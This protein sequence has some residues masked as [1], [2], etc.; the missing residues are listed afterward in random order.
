MFSELTVKKS[1]FHFTSDS[2]LKEHIG[3]FEVGFYENIFNNQYILSV[4]AFWVMIWRN[5]LIMT[6]MTS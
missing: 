5:N 3:S 4:E 2:I 6:R 1:E